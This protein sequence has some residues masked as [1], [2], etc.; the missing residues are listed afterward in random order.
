M[1]YKCIRFN[2]NQYNIQVRDSFETEQKDLSVLKNGALDCPVC[3]QTVSDVP[4]DSVRCTR[5][6]HS[7]AATLRNSTA[8]SAIIHRTVRCATE[9]T[10]EPAEQRLPARNGRL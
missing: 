8:R 3:H 7:E 4:P 5:A 10:G 1:Y 2:T 6:V 9:L